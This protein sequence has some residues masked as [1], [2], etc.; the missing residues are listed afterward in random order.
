MH[1]NVIISDVYMHGSLT[2]CLLLWL[3]TLQMGWVPPLS[4]K[5]YEKALSTIFPSVSKVAMS[6]IVRTLSSC[7][8]N[9]SFQ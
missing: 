2:D 9:F 3:H 4:L 1:H 6:V 5:S 8:K 7:R